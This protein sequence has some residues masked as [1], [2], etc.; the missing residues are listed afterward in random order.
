MMKKRKSVGFCGKI[1][2]AGRRR[3][4]MSNY[5]KEVVQALSVIS[6]QLVL[7]DS[8]LPQFRLDEYFLSLLFRLL[9]NLLWKKMIPL[10][11]FYK[12]KIFTLEIGRAKTSEETGRWSGVG[13]VDTTAPVAARIGSAVS[14]HQ[15]RSLGDCL[16]D[17]CSVHLK[18]FHFNIRLKQFVTLFIIWVHSYV[19]WIDVVTIVAVVADLDVIRRTLTFVL[20]SRTSEA[21]WTSAVQQ[22]TS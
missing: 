5:S 11:I 6:Y 22:V 13:V 17:S 8:S 16:I 21:E 19:G 14:A 20:A 18:I 12:E 10:I 9:R 2:V 7:S 15:T 1:I 3:Q 4:K